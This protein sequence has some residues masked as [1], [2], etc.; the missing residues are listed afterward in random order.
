MF[1][2]KGAFSLHHYILIG[3]EVHQTFCR[4]D[5]RAAGALINMTV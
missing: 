2:A 4:V 1:A 3:F 5:T